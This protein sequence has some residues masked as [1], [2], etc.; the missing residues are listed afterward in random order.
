MYQVPQVETD[1]VARVNVMENF[2]LN[3]LLQRTMKIDSCTRTKTDN[4]T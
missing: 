2:V 4:N 1:R 3:I